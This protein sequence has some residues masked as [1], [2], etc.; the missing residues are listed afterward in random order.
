MPC[1]TTDQTRW[2]FLGD[3]DADVGLRLRR[4]A[5]SAGGETGTGREEADVDTLLRHHNQMQEKL[6][7]EMVYLARSLKENVKAAGRVVRDDKEVNMAT[8]SLALEWT[9][10]YGTNCAIYYM[11]TATRLKMKCT[12]ASD[13]KPLL[14][15]ME[16]S[17]CCELIK[18]LLWGTQSMVCLDLVDWDRPWTVESN[19]RS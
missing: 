14:Y 2:I 18:I 1:L 8:F 10:L 12:G 17:Q 4:T 7:E 3:A 11:L 19:S 6:A 9:L 5:G 16:K 13:S 15:P